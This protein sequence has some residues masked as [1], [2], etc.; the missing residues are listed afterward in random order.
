MSA[1]PGAHAER[2]AQAWQR[3]GLAAAAVGVLA[4]RTLSPAAGIALATAGAL[5]AVLV[6]P[7][8]Y[9]R[10]RAGTGSPVAPG[11][12]LG[13]ALVPVLA[14]LALAWPALS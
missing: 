5:A 13:A 1:P 11:L 2:T 7:L 4:A 8:R 3:T 12:V 9:A 10:V 14:A 6:A